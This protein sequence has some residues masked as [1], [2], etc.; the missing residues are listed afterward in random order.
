MKRT[1]VNGHP[2][3]HSTGHTFFVVAS[4]RSGST[5]LARI[6]DMAAN[7]C[8][9]IE[10]APNLN[11]ES[12]LAMDGRLP[13]TTYEI[14]ENLVL[15]RVASGLAEHEIYGEKSVTYA[16]F[17]NALYHVTGC[18]FV[19][20]TRD[21]RDVVRSMVDWH[22]G[23]FGSIYRE[24]RNPGKLS[25]EALLAAAALPV[26]LDTSDFSR[27]RPQ[28]GDSL[29]AEWTDLRRWEMCAYYWS[30]KNEIYLDALEALPDEA[31]IRIDYTTPTADDVL[32]VANFLGL[33]GLPRKNVQSALDSR[34]NSLAD[35]GSETATPALGWPDWNSGDR[36][37]FDRIAGTTMRRLGYYNEHATRWQPQGYGSYWKTHDGGLAWYEW[38]FEGRRA[39]HDDLL[40]WIDAHPE[41]ISI[42][43]LGCGLGVGYADQLAGR[44][45]CGFDLSAQNIYWCQQHRTNPMHRYVCSDF[46]VEPTGKFDLVFSQG[47]IDNGYDMDEYLQAAVSMARKWI[48]ITAYRGWSPQ[49]DQHRYSWNA[50]HGCFY[51][52][53]SPSR[54]T[55]LLGA[56][57]CQDIEVRALPTGNRDI[58]NETRIIARVPSS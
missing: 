20:Q 5:S 40:E 25:A 41:L 17:I 46:I 18:R 44:E 42:A 55:H 32:E 24:A 29:F 26:H 6:L 15:P 8:C 12:R 21:G 10:P 35:R 53:L 14:V 3:G 31:Y 19:Y 28:P 56:L 13:A 51:N 22:T 38:M 27:P 39:A 34:I 30:R 23:K 9:E 2:G 36:D 52:D 1:N 11:E 54:V 58:P 50:E 48:Y 7:G 16:P 45:Y 37:A 47:T 43:D 49:L 33:G 4:S 57:G